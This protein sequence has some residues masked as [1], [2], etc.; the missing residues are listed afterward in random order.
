M[1]QSKLP[2]KFWSDSLL[3]AT[4]IV[5]RLP[6]KL[7]NWKCPYEVLNGHKPD[8]SRMKIFG[9]LC[10]ATNV[11]LQKSEFDQRAYRRILLGYPIGFRV[12]KLYNLDT[13]LSA[14]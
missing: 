1:F 6:T 5:N 4:Y 12:Y 7:L 14:S 2:K 11:Q 10:Y 8:Y 13:N 3:T 9:S